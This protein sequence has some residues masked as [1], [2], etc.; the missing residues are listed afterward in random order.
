[1]GTRRI[2]GAAG[3][4]GPAAGL[5]TMRVDCLPLR[6]AVALACCA[7]GVQGCRGNSAQK[8]I[9]PVYD[10]DTGRLRQLR[11]DSDSNGK[12][13]TVSHM[14]GT[15]VLRIEIDKDEDGKV[16]RWEYYDAA[17]KLERVGMSRA[18]DG[19][20]DAWSYMGPDGKVSRVAISTR[21]DGSISRTEFFQA[22]LPTSAEED[23]DGDGAIDKWESYEAGRLASVAFDSMHRGRPGRRLTYS[24]D[25]SV[26]VEVDPHGTGRWSPE[27][28]E[29]RSVSKRAQQSQ[30]L[31][32]RWERSNSGLA[33]SGREVAMRRL[34]AVVLASLLVF[35]STPRTSAA[36]KSTGTI[37]GVARSTAGQ[38]LG[39]HS[40][41]VRSVEPATRSQRRRP[42]PTV[43]LSSRISIRAATWSK[44]ST[45]RKDRRHERDAIVAEEARR[46]RWSQQRRP[47]RWRYSATALVITLVAAAA[48]GTTAIVLATTGDESS[49]SRS[50]LKGGLRVG[51]W[52]LKAAS[53]RPLRTI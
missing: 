38:P 32:P 6:V 7:L 28:N 51:T 9:E 17:R 19:V 53:H 18:N 26:K 50:I 43:A 33:L 22:D 2:L 29:G 4:S 49:P 24:P 10:P 13:D 44:S 48:L 15:R 40:V 25:G 37:T 39:G 35:A 23:T 46:R 34:I 21:R 11:Y 5:M 45:R 31:D 12:V 20:E 16:E 8:N 41:R 14:D 1:M 27:K 36:A 3:S 42:A 47:S 30:A 52:V